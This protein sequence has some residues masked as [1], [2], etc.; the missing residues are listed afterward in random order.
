MQAIGRLS[1]VIFAPVTP[2]DLRLT[3][4]NIFLALMQLTPQG[5]CRAALEQLVA[6][7]VLPR[8]VGLV[9]TSRSS[10]LLHSSVLHLL[11]RSFLAGLP[12]AYYE[13]TMHAEL[14]RLLAV[15]GCPSLEHKAFAMQCLQHALLAYPHLVFA[16]HLFAMMDLYHAASLALDRV[17]GT[18]T[19]SSSS[20]S[21]WLA[22]AAAA[23]R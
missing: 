19:S 22:A 6:L 9:K 5:E 20:P 4:V 7:D 23:G 10:T 11:R 16:D 8:L 18:C 15:V 12:A 13:K 17:K 3:I 2:P 1:A 21:S 14:C